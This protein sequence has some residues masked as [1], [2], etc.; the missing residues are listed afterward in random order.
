MV[1][2]WAL[3]MPMDQMF[4]AALWMSHHHTN[5]KGRMERVGL[6]VNFPD[7]ETFPFQTLTLFFFFR[8]ERRLGPLLR[9]ARSTRQIEGNTGVKF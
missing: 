2:P 6:S 4:V 1:V 8:T 7:D 5:R 3:S 9:S